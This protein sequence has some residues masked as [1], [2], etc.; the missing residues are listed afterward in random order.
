MTATTPTPVDLADLVVGQELARTRHEITRDTLVRYAG[1]S[2]DFNPIHYNDTVATEAGLPGVIAHG[3]LTMGTAVTGL[4]DAIADPTAVRAYTTRF[5]NPIPVPATGAAVLEVSAVVAAIDE[6]ARTARV[7]LT[8]EF[9]GTKVLG[10]AR[11][12]LALP[13]PDSAEARTGNDAA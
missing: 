13:G 8:A 9:D 10:R 7:D 1:A 5:T 11:A 2:G 6:A 3:M 12:T 4:L